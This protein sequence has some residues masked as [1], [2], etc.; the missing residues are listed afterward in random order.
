LAEDPIL[1]SLKQGLSAH[2]PK[3]RREAFDKL[4]PLDKPAA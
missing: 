4:Y 3:S 1:T 2:G